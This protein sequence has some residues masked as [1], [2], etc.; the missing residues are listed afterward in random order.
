M[1]NN[2]LRT[3][4]RWQENHLFFCSMAFYFIACRAGACSVQATAVVTPGA[5]GLEGGLVCRGL[6]GGE[7]GM[8]SVGGPWKGL[9]AQAVYPQSYWPTP[10]GLWGLRVHSLRYAPAFKPRPVWG[11]WVNFFRVWAAL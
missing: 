2:L 1:M 4:L 3:T 8:G 10:R 9:R 5:W 6:G 11:L 7:C